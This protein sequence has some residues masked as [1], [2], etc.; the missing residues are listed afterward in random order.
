MKQILFLQ[1]LYHEF[2]N[3]N[4]FFL[5][6]ITILFRKLEVTLRG[7]K[8]KSGLTLYLNIIVSLFC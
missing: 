1:E 5:I 3:R 8:I 6:V 4:S 7:L 2:F